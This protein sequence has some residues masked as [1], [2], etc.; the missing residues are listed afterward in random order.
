MHRIVELAEFM[1]R[2]LAPGR[3]IA[4]DFCGLRPGDK[5]AERLWDSSE[6]ACP[7]PSGGLVFVESS[8]PPSAA[9]QSGLAALRSAVAWRDLG[10]ALGQLR[11][12]VPGFEPSEKVLEL[13]RREERRVLV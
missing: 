13:A 7:L 11:A 8:R 9:W 12:L 5:L 6:V 10:A 1:A 4:V 3:E 2:R